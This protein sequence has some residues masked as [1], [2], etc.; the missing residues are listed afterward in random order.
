MI[1]ENLSALG[2]TRTRDLVV[3]VTTPLTLRHEIPFTKYM[4]A[5]SIDPI[6]HQTNMSKS[7]LALTQNTD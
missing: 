1:H 2:W 4:Y 6:K 7:G 5:I 3:I